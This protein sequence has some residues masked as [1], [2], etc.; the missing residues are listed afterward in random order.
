MGISIRKGS[1]EDEYPAR[2]QEIRHILDCACVVDDMLQDADTGD[3]LIFLGQLHG[4]SVRDINIQHGPMSIHHTLGPVITHVVNC[5]DQVPTIS[6]QMGPC[7]CSGSYV[8]DGCRTLR[9]E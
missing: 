6:E 3:C 4:R 2:F 5:S 1:C 7:G 9:S 8:Q